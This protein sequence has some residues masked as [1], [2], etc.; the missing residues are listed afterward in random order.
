MHEVNAYQGEVNF[1]GEKG[2]SKDFQTGGEPEVALEN[3]KS[4]VEAE[5]RRYLRSSTSVLTSR[6]WEAGSVT[7]ILVDSG[8][9]DE[10]TE[11]L[12]CKLVDEGPILE[13]G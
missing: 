13:W 8:A 12:R 9:A 11:T 7:A 1:K 6:W 5:T 2:D 4:W 10:P 3:A